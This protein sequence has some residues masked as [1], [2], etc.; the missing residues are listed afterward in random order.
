MDQIYR[1]GIVVGNRQ[2]GKPFC[3]VKFTLFDL[4]SRWEL[5]RDRKCAFKPQLHFIEN[6]R[7]IFSIVCAVLFAWAIYKTE[8]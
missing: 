7:F 2:P 6:N 8:G 1:Y 5:V 4:I 3:A